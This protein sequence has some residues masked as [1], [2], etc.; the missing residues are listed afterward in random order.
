[1]LRIGL[2]KKDYSEVFG[3]LFRIVGASTKTPLGI[4]PKGNTSGANISHL[5]H[6]QYLLT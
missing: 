6:C 5:S 3:Q 2:K 1:M 4:Y